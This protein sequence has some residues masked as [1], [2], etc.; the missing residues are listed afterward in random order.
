MIN[1]IIVDDEPLAIEVLESYVNQ[2]SDLK[3]VAKCGNALEADQVIRDEE[4]DLMLLDIN[5]PQLSGIDFVRSLKSPPLTVLTTAH[6][7]FALEGYD[8][9]VVDYLVKPIPTDRFLKAIQKV[10]DRMHERELGS[11]D[12]EDY[13]FVKADKKLIRVDFD[14]LIYIEGLKDYVIIRNSKDR[15]ITLQTMKSLELKLPPNRFKRIH[16]SYIVNLEKIKAIVGHMVEVEVKGERKH[17]PIG[18]NYRDELLKIIN[19][20]KL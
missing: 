13:F 2:I 19:D 12:D 9:D 16:R 3:L 5:M 14:E 11:M 4:V 6:P 8:L 20:R 15:V 7:E 10:R 18:K 17:I 1:T